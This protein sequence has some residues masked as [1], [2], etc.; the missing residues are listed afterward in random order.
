MAKL[1][2]RAELERAVERARRKRRQRRREI[3]VCCGTGCLANGAAE[4]AAGLAE[5][6]EAGQL[7]VELG[8]FTKQTGCHGFCE[9]GPLVIVQP[10]GILYTKVKPKSART[11]IERTVKRGEVI[12]SLLYR[13]PGSKQTIERYADRRADCGHCFLQKCRLS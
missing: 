11:I 1:E 8:L 10:E 13:V 6:I 9:R 12:E 7:D 5:V 3:L 2:S 4:V